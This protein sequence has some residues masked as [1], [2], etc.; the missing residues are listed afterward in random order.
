MSTNDG[1][2]DFEGRVAF[3][4][5]GARGIGLGIVRALLRRGA[6]VAI[7]DISAGA[8]ERARDRLGASPARL[9]CYQLDVTD[10]ERYARVAAEVHRDLG[11]V[12]LLFNNAGIIDSVSPSKLSYEMWGHVMGVNLD[13]VYNG[14]QTFVPGMLASPRRCHVVNTSSE[15]GLVEAGSGFLYHAS[16]Y[17][18]IGMSESLRRELAHFDVGVSVLFPGPVATDIVENTRSLRPDTA[19]P[20]SERVTRILDSAHKLLNDQGASPDGVGELVLGAVE[21]N[22][23]YIATRNELGEYLRRRNDEL[24]AAMRH[25]ESFLASFDATAEQA[26]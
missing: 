5:G 2:T 23:A 16:K 18:V 20:H 15:A 10:R 17:A 14:I 8:L 24:T 7:A 11:E 26:V 6:N 22:A 4:T 13:G 9:R 12:T 1:I 19:P 25:A 21:T 3:V